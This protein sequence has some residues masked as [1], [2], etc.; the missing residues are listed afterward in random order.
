MWSA[1]LRANSVE[2][3]LDHLEQHQAIALKW[4]VKDHDIISRNAWAVCTERPD[5]AEHKGEYEDIGHCR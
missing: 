1:N 5:F 2:P 4:F 3:A